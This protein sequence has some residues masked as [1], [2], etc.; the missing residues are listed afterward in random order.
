[1]GGIPDLTGGPRVITS[2][3]VRGGK[4][5][6]AEKVRRSALSSKAPLYKCTDVGLVRPSVDQGPPELRSP[7]RFFTVA[8]GN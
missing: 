6:E 1:M 7:W 4:G 8:I 5:V 2:A 3:L